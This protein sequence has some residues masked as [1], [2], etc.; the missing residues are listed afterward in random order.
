MLVMLFLP[1]LPFAGGWRA[2]FLCGQVF[3]YL[4]LSSSSSSSSV[5]YL[6]QDCTKT[7]PGRLSAYK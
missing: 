7:T 5:S 4:S 3:M 2:F 1:L 6:K